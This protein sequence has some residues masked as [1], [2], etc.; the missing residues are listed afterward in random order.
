VL[1]QYKAVLGQLLKRWWPVAASLLV[2]M[3]LG[4]FAAR[5]SYLLK[6]V[7]THNTG[8]PQLAYDSNGF[9]WVDVKQGLDGIAHNPFGHGPGTAG[10][11]SIQ[12]PKGSFL[13]ENYYIQLGYEVGVLGLAVFIAVNVFLYRKLLLLKDRLLMVVLLCSFWAYVATNMLF[14]MWSNE[15]VAAQWWLLA[16]L[17]LASLSPVTATTTK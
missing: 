2:V 13:T 14:H 3:T 9:H 5:H 10:L 1:W 17:A 8:K 7:V 4:L 12:N 11:A 15:A 6:S 16:G